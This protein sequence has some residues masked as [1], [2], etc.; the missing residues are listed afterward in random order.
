MRALDDQLPAAVRVRFAHAALQRIGIERGVRMLHVKGPAADPTLRGRASPGSDA[1]LLVHPADLGALAAGLRSAGW[2]EVTDFAGSPFGHASNWW[3]PHWGYADVH[4]SFPGLTVAPA[5]AFERLWAQRHTVE[6]A[7]TA[8][9]VPSRSAQALLLLLHAARGE[10]IEQ[11]ARERIEVWGAL[12]AAEIAEVEQLA[13]VLRAQ[14]ALAA[15]RGELERFREAP[16]YALWASFGT[17]S[18]P[19]ERWLAR[20]RSTHGVDRIRLVASSLVVRRS[21]LE[22]SLGRPATR[23]DVAREYLARVRRIGGGR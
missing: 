23:A 3:H 6:L 13:D 1:D 20:W 9:D 2:R 11:A 15:A 7:S 16:D 19:R 17:A 8:C 4:R 10:G 5:V 14:T 18:S 22:S 21:V 12:D